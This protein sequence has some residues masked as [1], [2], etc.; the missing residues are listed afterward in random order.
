MTQET[1]PAA[2]PR[3]GRWRL[4]G[5]FAMA[6]LCLAGAFPASAVTLAPSQRIEVNLGAQPWTYYSED[7]ET[8][9]IDKNAT[10]ALN[11]DDSSWQVVGMPY[12]STQFNTFING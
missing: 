2:R 3:G 6:A 4:S 7:N 1:V 8:D 10:A 5:V 12:S 9:A 11:F